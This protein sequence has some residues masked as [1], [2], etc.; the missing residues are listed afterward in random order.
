MCI[1]DR[2]SSGA[3]RT[4]AKKSEEAL[5]RT[6]V[7]GGFGR[8]SLGTEITDGSR[9]RAIIQHTPLSASLCFHPR[10]MDLIVDRGAEAE[11]DNPRGK[12]RIE[13]AIIF[14]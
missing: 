10:S 6:V 8:D 3:Q 5:E 4:A 9:L 13:V 7:V 12:L 14:C 11:L 2:A 1:R